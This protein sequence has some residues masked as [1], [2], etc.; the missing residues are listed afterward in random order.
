[1]RALGPA[2]FLAALPGLFGQALP[3]WGTWS[4]LPTDFLDMDVAVDVRAES[5]DIE[6]LPAQRSVGMAS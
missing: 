5:E 4:G 6:Q 2:L 1:M 3:L